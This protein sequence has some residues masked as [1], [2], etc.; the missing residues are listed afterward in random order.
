[1]ELILEHP[2]VAVVI[3]LPP[4]LLL[5]RR[6]TIQDNDPKVEV[7]AGR[8]VDPNVMIQMWHRLDQGAETAARKVN[9]VD[10]RPRTVIHRDRRR[11]SII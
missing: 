7:K 2:H 10:Q 4:P 1:M 8:K 5:R 9:T 6:I 3:H 11:F